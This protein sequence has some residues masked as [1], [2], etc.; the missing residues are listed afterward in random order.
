MVDKRERKRSDWADRKKPSSDG[1]RHSG[2]AFVFAVVVDVFA[3]R[4]R[5]GTAWHGM[6]PMACN[7]LGTVHFAQYSLFL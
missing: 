7:A 1:P 5:K 6:R 4:L 2:T 3:V